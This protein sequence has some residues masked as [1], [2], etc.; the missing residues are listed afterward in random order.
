M[1]ERLTQEERDRLLPPLG[2]AGWGADPETDAIRKI[3]KFRSFS[4][5][6]GFMSRVALLAEKSGHHPDWRNVYNVVDLRLTTHACDGLSR[7]DVEMAP[8]ID[9][10][11]GEA[12]VQRDQTE[13]IVCLCK[14]EHA[15][16]QGG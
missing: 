9:A 6:W 4:E 10:L 2:E 3:W 15:R 12:E 11:A 13:A 8:R 5:A 7:L 1:V 16:A 14:V